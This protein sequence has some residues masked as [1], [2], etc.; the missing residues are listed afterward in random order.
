LTKEQFNHIP[1]VETGRKNLQI[2]D[3]GAK[4]KKCAKCYKQKS[5]GPFGIGV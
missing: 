1:F 2:A 4:G 3:Q 5:G